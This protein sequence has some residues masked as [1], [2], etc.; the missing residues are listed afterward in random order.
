VEVEAIPF[1]GFE[2]AIAA[3]A[4]NMVAF[5]PY[6]L[7]RRF[8]ARWRGP[9]ILVYVLVGL[10]LGLAGACLLAGSAAA[11]LPG[12]DPERLPFSE[13]LLRF[14]PECIVAGLVGGLTYWAAARPRNVLRG[15]HA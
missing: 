4:I 6:L 12:G 14:A 15:D 9:A 10:G 1:Y 11:S 13:G 8:A 5:A 7:V 3:L 2:I